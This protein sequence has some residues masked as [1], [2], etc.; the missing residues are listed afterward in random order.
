MK[1]AEIVK[2]LI[3]ET[4]L[5]LKAFAEKAN[6]PYTTLY[7]ILERGVGNASV[8]NVI[9]ICR[10]LNISVDELQD[11]A[12]DDKPKTKPKTIA[13]HLD[14][15]ELSDQECQE[16]HNFIEYLLSKRNR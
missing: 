11:M 13:A 4:G 6:I 16:L 2:K 7:S 5:S 1:R 14:G 8:D 10:A 15:V 12:N 9:K 3:K